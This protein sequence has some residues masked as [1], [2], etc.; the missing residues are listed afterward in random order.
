M[1]DEKWLRCIQYSSNL[2]HFQEGVE[3]AAAHWGA[4]GLQIHALEAQ[5][6][7]MRSRR[8]LQ[9]KESRVE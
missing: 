5:V 2:A 1:D 6:A 3:G 7:P 9:G 8:H 4:H